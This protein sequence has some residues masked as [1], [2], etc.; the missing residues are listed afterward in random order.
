MLNI[1]TSKRLETENLFL[2]ISKICV[3]FIHCQLA[4]RLK[5]YFRSG[6]RLLPLCLVAKMHYSSS[7][8]KCCKCGKRWAPLLKSH[9]CIYVSTSVWL[10]SR[11]YSLHFNIAMVTSSVHG[12]MELPEEKYSAG[13]LKSKSS[14]FVCLCCNMCSANPHSFSQ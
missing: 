10:L 8:S 6:F 13:F 4:D 12:H 9:T 5:Q 1:L 11:L 2:H 3:H 14:N 7:V